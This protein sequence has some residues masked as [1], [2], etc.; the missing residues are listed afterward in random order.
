MKKK[1]KGLEKVAVK[2]TELMIERI[3][4][5]SDNWEKPWIPVKKKNFYPRNISGRR[6]SGGNTIMLLFHMLF[7]PYRTPVFLTY[8]QATD[9]GLVVK[10]GAFPV[11]HFTY[12]YLHRDSREK[13]SEKEYNKLSEIEQ[14][15]YIR[16]PIAKYYN[17]FNLD[18]TDYEQK[19]PEEWEKLINH[20]QEKIEFSEGQMFDF[21][22][23][24]NMLDLQSWDCPVK[25]Q[26]Q[27]RAY[28]S[29]TNDEV[30]LPV[31]RQFI[32][33][34]KFY[35]TLLHEMSHSTGH[36]TRLNRKMGQSTPEYAK[37]ELIAELSSALLGYFMGIET[38][39]R[40]ENAAYL[41]HWIGQ[42]DAEPDFLMDILSDIVRIVNY[43]IDKIGFELPEEVNIISAGKNGRE[44]KKDKPQVQMPA[45]E[46]EKVMIFD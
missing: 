32:A 38:S 29:L 11:Y 18:L 44:E 35:S 5:I 39:V 15:Q 20:Y 16:F 21:P 37:E 14:D 45:T 41:K 6:Y 33:G 13:I 10:P 9:L 2:F 24:D 27:S 31:K 42:L 3:K 26:V 28:Y 7:Q 34:E 43:T 23:L 4:E 8:N 22:L 19:Y 46:T 36:K 25:L 17:V 30:C 1:Y 40:E 12:M